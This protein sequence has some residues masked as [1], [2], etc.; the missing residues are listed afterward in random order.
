MNVL[1][2]L[3]NQSLFLTT[4]CKA[5][6]LI[7]ECSIFPYIIVHIFSA[8]ASGVNKPLRENLDETVLGKKEQTQLL[9]ATLTQ[10]S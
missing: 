1:F 9:M 3:L 6:A 2:L 10:E 8:C 7:H 4:R 5:V